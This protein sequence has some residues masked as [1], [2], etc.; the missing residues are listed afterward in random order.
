MKANVGDNFQMAQ[1]K[2]REEEANIHTWAEGE[3]KSMQDKILTTG[4]FG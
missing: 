2:I 3:N 1:P 4:E